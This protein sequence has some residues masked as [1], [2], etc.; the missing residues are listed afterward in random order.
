M[1]LFH[2]TYRDRKG[3]RRTAARW[4]IEFRDHQRTIRQLSAFTD[5]RATRAFADRI[6]QLVEL[7]VAGAT[8]DANMTRWIG[9]LPTNTSERLAVIGLLDADRVASIKPLIDHLSDYE[10]FLHDSGATRDYVR[11]TVF[12]A[13]AILD[14]IG[15]VFLADISGEAVSGYLASRRVNGLSAKSSNHYLAAIKASCSWLVKERRAV[16]SPI[17]HLSALNAN[18]D[19]RHVR[20]ALELDELQ[21]LLEAARSGPDRFGI[22]GE[23][24]YWLYRLAL[25]TGLR[26]GELRSLT[27][28]CIDLDETDPTVTIGAASTKNGRAATLPL[29]PDTAFELR[30]FLANKLPTAKVFN[31][32]RPENV[33]VMLRGDLESAGIPYAD[34]TGRVADFHALRS[35]FASLLLRSGVDVRTAKEL[36]RHSTIAMTADVYA[37]TFRG[38]LSAAVKQLPEFSRPS[39][40]HAKATGTESVSASCLARKR[41]GAHKAVRGSAARRSQQPGHKSLQDQGVTSQKGACRSVTLQRV[42]SAPNYPQGESNPCLQDEN[43]IS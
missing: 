40:E 24:R 18:A 36:M 31:M 27:R 26:S 1:R 15:T 30:A 11:K 33:V 7:R 35:T 10:Q 2:T 22:V 43:L 29:R 5:K 14:G 20:R 16:E 34:E 6:E 13:R 9:T 19:R 25:E 38:S 42:H 3:A 32:P 17:A 28:A 21:R 39:S 8:P 12:R 37:C 41:A 4:Y 23:Q